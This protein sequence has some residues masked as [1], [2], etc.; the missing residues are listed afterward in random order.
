[1]RTKAEEVVG[2]LE[3]APEVADDVGA[4]VCRACFVL[5][6]ESLDVQ[7][8][9]TRTALGMDLEPR[10]HVTVLY[11]GEVAREVANAL[12]NEAMEFEAVEVTPTDPQL[13]GDLDTL[14]VGLDS[15]AV[16]ALRGE[17]LARHAHR[18]SAE[19]H[20]PY[21]PHVTLGEAQAVPEGIALEPMVLDRLELW[22]DDVPAK[23]WR[24]GES[25]PEL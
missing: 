11:L 14:V 19:Q 25:G 2:A 22:V 16:M 17:L 20:Y 5:T 10:A 4:E 1:M 7:V 8:E 24:L 9:A 21:R 23:V 13:F 18:V 6:A 3:D 15:P 12:G